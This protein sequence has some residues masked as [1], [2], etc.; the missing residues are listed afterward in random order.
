[1]SSLSTSLS[2]NASGMLGRHSLTAIYEGGN[3]DILTDNRWPILVCWGRHHKIPDWVLQW[4]TLLFSQFW[5]PEVH[6]QQVQFLA[7]LPSLAHRRP[8]SRCLLTLPFL[9]GTEKEPVSSPLLIKI[10]ILSHRGSPGP[11]LTLIISTYVITLGLK[12]LTYEFC[13][14]WIWTPLSP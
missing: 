5:R 12:T 4:Q 2:H 13:P 3:V 1:M 7:R 14:I 9:W 6:D 8:L 10:P 11:H